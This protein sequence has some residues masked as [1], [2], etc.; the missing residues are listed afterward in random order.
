M[1]ILP[2]QGC[3]GCHA[4]LLDLHEKFED[5][6]N[7]IDIRFTY[8]MDVKQ[9]PKVDIAIVEGCVA[10]HENE[11]RLKLMRANCEI[12][13]ALGSC[14]SFG[15]IPGLRNLHSADAVIRRAYQESESTGKNGELPHPQ[16]VPVLTDAVRA[17][18]DV[19]KVDF[20]IPGCPSPHDLIL[21]ALAQILRG[22]NPKMPTRAVCFECGREHRTLHNGMKEFIAPSINPIMCVEKIDENQC[23]LEQ[24]ILCMGIVTMEGCRARCLKSN[25]PCQGCMGPA[26]EV[27]DTGAK[28]INTMG[29]LLPSGAMR[30]RDDI[31]GVGYR[32]TLP[33][34]MAPGKNPQRG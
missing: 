23:F 10:N 24:G 29:S 6:V 25:F 9:I 4:N 33:V 27:K 16:H 13:I 15:G 34:A 20:I 22:T 5:L 31:V 1:A 17:I 7:D 2:L 28:W 12:L 19:V 8:L 14:A 3:F 32:Y 26:P 21:S 30:F 18:T 11:E